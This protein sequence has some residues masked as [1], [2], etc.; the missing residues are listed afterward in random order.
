MIFLDILG[1]YEK[2]TT[3]EQPYHNINLMKYFFQPYMGRG[4]LTHF[5]PYAKKY[6]KYITLLWFYLFYL[7]SALKDWIFIK[8]KDSLSGNTNYRIRERYFR[9]REF[10]PS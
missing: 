5:G 1:V 3:F 2:F 4:Y 6:K 7:P 9:K 8:I 10:D